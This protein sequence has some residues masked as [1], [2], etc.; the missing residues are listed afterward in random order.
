MELKRHII[1]SVPASAA[2]YYV[3]GLRSGLYFLAG[4]VLWDLDHVFDYVVVN[5]KR[6]NLVSFMRDYNEYGVPK[7]L[8]ILHSW[9]IWGLSFL[10]GVF[11]FKSSLFLISGGFYH[12]ILDSFFNPALPYAY[13]LFHRIKKKLKFSELFD[14]YAARR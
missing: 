4:S 5:R 9:E 13:F 7:T 12:L 3:W 11:F 10:A 2:V 14:P 6:W 1:F 8:L